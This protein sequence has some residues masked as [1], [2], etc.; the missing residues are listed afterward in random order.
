MPRIEW[1]GIIDNPADY[2]R[3]YLSEKCEKTKYA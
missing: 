2:Q 3:G 1:K